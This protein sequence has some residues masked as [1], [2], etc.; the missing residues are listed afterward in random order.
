MKL[1]DEILSAAQPG[2]APVSRS[3]A[4]SA[5][6]EAPYLW[7]PLLLYLKQA[8]G[9]AEANEALLRRLA[10]LAPDR[11]ALSLQLGDDVS[12]FV[13]FYPPGEP[14]Q[15]P[16]TDSAIEKFLNTYGSHSERE[17]EVL[18]QAIF[19]PQP[20]YS[21]VL[22]AQEAATAGTPPASDQDALIDNFIAMARGQE[23]KAGSPVVERHVDDDEA[24][25][26][27]TTPVNEPGDAPAP[28]MSEGLARLYI[29]K[30]NYS[31]ALEIIEALN[32]NNPQKS[33]YFAA[34]IR[35]LKKLIINEQ[36]LNINK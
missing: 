13:D 9:D 27:A 1:I 35:F 19:N 5:G 28:S 6:R 20:D 2:S 17:L 15:T 23:L 25:A 11:K 14:E 10:I 34:Q 36:H 32:L 22:A 33:V 26:V 12:R 3:W 24:A 21:E 4:E 18:Q 7:V 30:G 29:A 16:E 8:K 31:R